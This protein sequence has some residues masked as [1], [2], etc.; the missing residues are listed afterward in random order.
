M[1]NCSFCLEKTENHLIYDCRCKGCIIE[2][3][4]K[5]CYETH[6]KFHEK[7]EKFNRKQLELLDSLT[8]SNNGKS[9]RTDC[10]NQTG[11]FQ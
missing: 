8:N 9:T 3:L 10:G 11:F 7:K 2:N 4:C 1:I 6:M 5:N